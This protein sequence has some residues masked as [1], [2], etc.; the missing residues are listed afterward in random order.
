MCL[1]QGGCDSHSGLR[2]GGVLERLSYCL[3]SFTGTMVAHSTPSAEKAFLS[4]SE[5]SM[6][7]P[8]IT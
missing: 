7:W 5:Q 6:A 2:G 8:G 3:R 4:A 1:S